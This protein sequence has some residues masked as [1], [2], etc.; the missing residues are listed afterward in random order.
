MS[1]LHFC[2]HNR[3]IIKK[4]FHQFIQKYTTKWFGSLMPI[5]NATNDM[6]R[7]Q[8]IQPT[9]LVSIVI[10]RKIKKVIIEFRN[11]MK[12]DSIHRIAFEYEDQEDTNFKDDDTSHSGSKGYQF[13]CKGDSGGGHW[14]EQ[15]IA[16]GKRLDRAVLVGITTNVEKDDRCV[17]F[18]HMQK[19]LTLTFYILLK[20]W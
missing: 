5:N 7:H 12:P 1:E 15:C 19:L 8:I 9:S 6:A 3:I 16:H 4:D 2:I 10:F 20:K 13:P 11:G 18:T 17:V 14:L